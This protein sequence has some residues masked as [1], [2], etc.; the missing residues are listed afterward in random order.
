MINGETGA[1]QLQHECKV[2]ASGII[3]VASSCNGAILGTQLSSLPV[4]ELGEYL[5]VSILKERH[6]VWKEDFS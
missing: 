5:R 4:Y 6:I 1:G 3:N 2:S